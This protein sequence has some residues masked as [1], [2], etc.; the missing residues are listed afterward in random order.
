M[1]LPISALRSVEGRMIRARSSLLTKY[2]LLAFRRLSEA[3]RYPAW[4]ACRHRS[5][6]DERHDALFRTSGTKS[7]RKAEVSGFR[8]LEAEQDVR[9]AD[10]RCARM[11]ELRQQ[12]IALDTVRDRVVTRVSPDVMQE[13]AGPEG[14]EVNGVPPVQGRPY[15]K[16][17]VRDR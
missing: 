3:N 4:S 12:R 2:R 9:G 17:G 13:G 10:E 7:R 11:A 1:G 15:R 8:R 14:F 6:I 16:R 5:E